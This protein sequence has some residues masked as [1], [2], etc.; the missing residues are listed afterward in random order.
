MLRRMPVFRDYFLFGLGNVGLNHTERDVFNNIFVQMEKV[1][2]VGFVGT[3]EARDLREGGNILWGVKDGPGLKG[4]PFAKFRN[5]PL[6]TD[7]RKRYEPG[8]TTHDRIADPK[9][10]GLTNAVDL[11]LQPDSP[12]VNTGRT[13][14]RDW[15]D[16]LRDADR[17]EPDIGALPLGA[18][19]WG[20]GV[21]GR[22]SLF[23][24]SVVKQ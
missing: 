24:G 21:D 8:W 11:R 9:F 16:P 17:G 18:E 12:A 13:V 6:F 7:S 19:A 5:S 3:K 14:P 20:V 22:V 23:T 2:G 1:P 4:D 15:P 10:V